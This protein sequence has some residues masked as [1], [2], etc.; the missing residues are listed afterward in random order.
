MSLYL[1]AAFVAFAAVAWIFRRLRRFERGDLAAA[2]GLCAAVIGADSVQIAALPS[3]GGLSKAAA[4]AGLILY[5]ASA[6][7]AL[8]LLRAGRRAAVAAAAFA[9]LGGW[10]LWRFFAWTYASL[11]R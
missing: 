8:V 7:A 4:A 6:V 5:A 2:A 10:V 11:V 1:T 9:L 3:A